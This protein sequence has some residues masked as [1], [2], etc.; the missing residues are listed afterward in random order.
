MVSPDAA[1]PPPAAAGAAAAPSG[2]S[3]APPGAPGPAAAA[4][5]PYVRVKQHLKDGL[6]AG[7]WPPGALMPSEAELV[8][9]FGVS[10]MTVNRALRELQ[11]EGLVTRTQGVGTFA[12]PLHRVSS[13]LTIRDLHEEIESRGHRHH[14]VVHR[15]RAERAPPA[16]AQQLGLASGARVFHSLIVHHENGVPLQCEDR[17]VNPGCCPG[18]LEA[19]FTAT[20]PTQLLFETTALWRAQYTIEAS[21]PTAEEA[22]LLGIGVREPCLVVTRR[23]FTA[24]AAITIA[25]LVHP[26][27]RYLLQGEFQP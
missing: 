21:A 24:D 14:A 7:R 23:T 19:D 18:Y 15:L 25:R 3:A 10:R 4:Q 13:T 17:Y 5:A 9:G 27:T 20:T 1:V 11:S 12:A 16:L 22:R 8:A 2:A 26:G 6:A